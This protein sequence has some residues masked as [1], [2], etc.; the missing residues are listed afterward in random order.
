MQPIKWKKDYGGRR[1]ILETGK[2]LMTGK[3]E[4][5]ALKVGGGGGFHRF[6]GGGMGG[7]ESRIPV[8]RS[9]KSAGGNNTVKKNKGEAKRGDLWPETLDLG[10]TQDSLSKEK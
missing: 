3:R 1:V 8:P 5:N 7:L 9:K 6:S 2:T 4:E 10:V